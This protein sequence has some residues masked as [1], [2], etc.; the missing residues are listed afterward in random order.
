MIREKN[1][2]ILL[3]EIVLILTLAL[4]GCWNWHELN[5]LG[6]VMASGFDLA[7]DGKISVTMQIVRPGEISN[8]RSEKGSAGS[9][10][11][12]VVTSTGDTVFDAVQ[13]ATMKVDRKLFWPHNKVFV[14][15][16]D[17][18]REGVSPVLDWIDRDPE[19]RRLPKLLVARGRAQDIMEVE[20]EL[21]NVSALYLENLVN[22]SDNTSMAVEVRIHDFLKMLVSEGRDPYA[23]R[24]ELLDGEKKQTILTGAAVF[25]KDWLAGWLDRS[26]TRG[27]LWVLGKVKSGVIVV[28]S[29]L[30]KE[31]KV[32]LEIIRANSRIE[33]I[34]KENGLPAI[35]VKIQEEGNLAEQMSV[36]DLT[37]PENWYLLEE[38]QAAA[39]ENE[40]KTVLHVAQNELGTDI[41]GFGEAVHRQYP[42]VWQELKDSW[43][44]IYP[45]VEVEVIVSA[46]LRR[47]GIS[48]KPNIPK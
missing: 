31:K 34:I 23:S 3:T 16:E 40:V 12:W 42:Q 45:S 17:L 2:R 36:D 27:L 6:I 20:S 11:V 5:T 18:A 22:V 19:S 8:P 4:T 44:Q 10:A 38:Y 35:I 37:K 24:I 47:T 46:K 48:T 9:E 43:P 1:T 26:E 14:I 30:E 32:S 33:P 29:P 7:P 41:F 15:G 13:N 28:P 39:I 25:R 21:E